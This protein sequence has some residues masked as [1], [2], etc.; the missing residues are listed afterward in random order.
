MGKIKIVIN[1]IMKQITDCFSSWKIPEILKKLQLYRH[2]KCITT[3]V[4]P[5]GVFITKYFS[6]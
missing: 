5:L 6:K 3:G 2:L 1:Q 4:S